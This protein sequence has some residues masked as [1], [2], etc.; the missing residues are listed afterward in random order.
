MLSHI[1][2]MHYRQQTRQF[3]IF[4][5]QGKNIKFTVRICQRKSEISNERRVSSF[6]HRLEAEHSL[7]FTKS[8]LNFI[9]DLITE[10]DG[11]VDKILLERDRRRLNISLTF[12]LP[13][14]V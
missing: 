12:H 6:P 10:F 4:L 7:L 5:E 2:P 9:E 13:L 14:A 3:P 1:A 8:A 11:R